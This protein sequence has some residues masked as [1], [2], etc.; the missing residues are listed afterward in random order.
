MAGLDLR[1]RGSTSTN[2]RPGTPTNDNDNNLDITNTISTRFA[3]ISK[4]PTKEFRPQNLKS[5][6]RPSKSS[7]L[8]ETF[9]PHQHPT[10]QT[11][12]TT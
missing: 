8:R 7:K 11:S 10:Q 3:Q 9:K 4:P 6:K 2:G 5:S 12:S 1:H